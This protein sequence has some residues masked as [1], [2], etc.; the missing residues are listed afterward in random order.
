MKESRDFNQ[1]FNCYHCKREVTPVRY[2]GHHRNH[3]PYC[4]Y[5]LH[6]DTDRPDRKGNCFGLMKPIGRY[7]RRT[8]EYVIAHRC[9]RCGFERYN[10]IAGDDNFELVTGL[11]EILPRK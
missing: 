2:G 11:P 6:I 3:C 8:G 7:S 5:S 1:Q 4:L 9:R 10:R